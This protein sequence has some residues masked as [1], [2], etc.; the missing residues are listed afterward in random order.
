[1][2]WILYLMSLDLKFSVKKSTLNLEF[3]LLEIDFRI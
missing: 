3:K 2:E 1:M